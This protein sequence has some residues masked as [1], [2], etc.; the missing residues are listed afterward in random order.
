M[1]GLERLDDEIDPVLLEVHL[2][3]HG[4]VHDRFLGH[5]TGRLVQ[6]PLRQGP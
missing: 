2:K 1:H 4:R 6:E 5:Q 3:G